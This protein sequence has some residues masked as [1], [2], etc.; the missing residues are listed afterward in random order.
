MSMN[1]SLDPTKAEAFEERMVD[2][3]NAGALALMISIGHRTGLFD[4]MAEL[5]PATSLEIAR[6]AELHERYVREWL[7]A[8]VAAGLVDYDASSQCYRLPRE[9]A[10]YLTRAAEPSNFA[11]FAQYIPLL[12]SVEDDVVRCFCEGGGVPYERYA[13]FHEVMAEGASRSR[14]SRA[15]CRLRP[16]PSA[17]PDGRLVSEQPLCRIRSFRGGDRLRAAGGR[18]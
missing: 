11:V 10:G 6:R 12:G 15:R 4:A 13:R 3:L 16:R 9:H 18:A 17:E 7:G 8:M 5:P 2:V 1:V 14:H